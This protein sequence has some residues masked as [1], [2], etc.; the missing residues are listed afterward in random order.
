MRI[1]TYLAEKHGLDVTLIDYPD[2]FMATNLRSEK[3]TILPYSDEGATHVPADAIL[4]LQAMNPWSIFPGLSVCRE[5]RLIFWNCLPFNLVPA[6]PGLREIS[7]RTPALLMASLSTLL[8]GRRKTNRQLVE[9]L[10]GRHSIFFMDEE[11]VGAVRRFLKARVDDPV[12]LPIPVAD[13][14][15]SVVRQA[16]DLHH[17]ALRVVWVGRIADFKHHILVR[18]MLDLDGYSRQS[19]QAVE[20]TI[21]GS[22]AFAARVADQGSELEFVDLTLINNV[23]PDQLDAF[24]TDRAD[25][26]MAMG[27]AA[28]DGARLGIP[29]I[30]LDPSYGPV[31][32]AYLYRWLFQESG[33]TLGR[34]LFDPA[35]YPGGTPLTDMLSDFTADSQRLSQLS[36][37]YVATN[38]A[39][40]KVATK[41]VYFAER[42]T[43]KWGDLVDSG[44]NRR[45]WI[46]RAFTFARNLVGRGR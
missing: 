23:P 34:I 19:K 46:Y 28:L 13:P 2:G 32:P 27:T 10:H 9:A 17:S 26:V 29:T 36:L 38:H 44:A 45:D 20:L 24:L 33:F 16:R 42:A 31:S 35:S 37:T 39:L 4:V 5:T 14:D 7:Y 41:L 6:L 1:G 40:P 21:V 43:Y 30:L 8:A 22:G 11:N 12:F 25:I 3:V 15:L 18:A